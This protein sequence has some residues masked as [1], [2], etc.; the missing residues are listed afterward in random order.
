MTVHGP[1]FKTLRHWDGS[2]HR[3]FEELCYQL[4]DRTLDASDLVKTGNPDAGLE[5]YVTRSGGAVWGWQAKYT[6]DI[7]TALDLMERSLK[8]VIR[9]RP[10]CRR[11]T[12]CVPFD[13]PDVP[14]KRAR[15][16]ARQ[17]FEDRKESWRRRIA[18]A[19]RVRIQLWSEGELLERLVGHPSQRGIER[20]FWDREVFSSDWCST[21]VTAALDAAGGRYT[22]ELHV[23]LP[24]AFSLG[25]LA[26]SEAY[27]KK[28]RKLR[29]AV[30]VAAGRIRV[31]DY[32]GLGVAEDLRRLVRSSA[33]WCRETPSS[34]AAAA[35]L[36]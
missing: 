19:N 26:R 30:A 28:Y 2:Q 7:D 24:I 15:K 33:T 4:R 34:F 1:D 8:T 10:M 17:K 6:F 11:L 29:G 12:F 14:G 27:W 20:F 16:L 35:R 5:W 23:D 21:R 13:L 3:A 36:V 18:G 31:S 22:P 32:T 9:E 25:G